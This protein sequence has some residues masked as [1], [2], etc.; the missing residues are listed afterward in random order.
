M[1]KGE[2]SISKII[3]ENAEDAPEG[4]TTRTEVIIPEEFVTKIQEEIDNRN[5]KV[6]LKAE[7]INEY[8]GYKPNAK[9]SK[10][11]TLKKKLNKQYPLD[12]N[13]EWHVRTVNNHETYIFI[14]RTKKVKVEE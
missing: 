12:N 8:F 14:Q 13:Q 7:V 6:S 5:G 4:I 10:A 3:E 9:Y 2:K 11:Y 1:S